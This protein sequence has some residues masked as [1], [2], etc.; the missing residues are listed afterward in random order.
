MTSLTDRGVD[1]SRSIVAQLSK[2][3]TRRSASRGLLQI[4]NATEKARFAPI[5][6]LN[7]KVFPEARHLDVDMRVCVMRVHSGL[8]SVVATAT[9]DG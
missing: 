1:H 3:P 4:R 8:T 7:F 9:G 6:R 5:E 2:Q